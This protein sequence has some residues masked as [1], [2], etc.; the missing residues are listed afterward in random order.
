MKTRERL[1]KMLAKA[2]GQKISKIEADVDRDTF[3]DAEEA[4][5]YGIVDKVYK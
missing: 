4:K 5:K 1:N 2:T 3:M